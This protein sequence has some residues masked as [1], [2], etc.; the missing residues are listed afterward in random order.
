MPTIVKNLSR[1]DRATLTAILKMA[2]YLTGLSCEV[3]C[4]RHAVSPG[5]TR[6]TV[7]VPR[8][9]TALAV[10][11]GSRTVTLGL[12]KLADVLTTKVLRK[13][14]EGIRIVGAVRDGG[15]SYLRDELARAAANLAGRSD[16]MCTTH[17]PQWDNTSP[18][19]KLRLRGVA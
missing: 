19:P 8:C 5:L 1:E 11:P 7:K 17:S 12:N 9:K 4:A 18:T 10:A 3:V 15:S 2:T 13:L 6:Y 16:A 14:Q